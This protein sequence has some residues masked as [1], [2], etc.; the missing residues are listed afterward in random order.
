MLLPVR[1]SLGGQLFVVINV[2]SEVCSTWPGALTLV[3]SI[4]KASSGLVC[5]CDVLTWSSCQ[6]C[7]VKRTRCEWAPGY[8]IPAAPGVAPESEAQGTDV[9]SGCQESIK[10][11]CK[12]NVICQAKLELT[13]H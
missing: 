12:V 3:V 9:P 8:A 11:Q 10:V 2:P 4:D 1:L 13:E 7:Y 6:E 5:M